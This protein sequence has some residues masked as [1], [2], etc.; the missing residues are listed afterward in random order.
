MSHVFLQRE[1]LTLILTQKRMLFPLLHRYAREG[2]RIFI[3]DDAAEA[4]VEYYAELRRLSKDRWVMSIPGNCVKEVVV[5]L[6]MCGPAS[7]QH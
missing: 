6:L 5:L 7:V 2:V 1:T 4:I 3:E